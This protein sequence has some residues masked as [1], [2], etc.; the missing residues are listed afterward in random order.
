MNI[1]TKA[2]SKFAKIGDYWDDVIV[3]KVS[4][5]LRKYQDLFRTKFSDLKGIIGDVGVMKITLNSYVKP[6]K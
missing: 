3:D 1:G 6:M 4:K 5:L 2:E